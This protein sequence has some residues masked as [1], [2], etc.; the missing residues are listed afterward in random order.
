MSIIYHRAF[1]SPLNT[2]DLTCQEDQFSSTEVACQNGWVGDTEI[3]TSTATIDLGMVCKDQWKKSFAQS[4][5]MAGMLVGSFC[6]GTMADWI[7][8]RITLGKKINFTGC[9][10]SSVTPNYIALY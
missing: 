6:F 5:Y 7:G 9:G 8:R 1:F 4:L 3:F 2:S 10:T